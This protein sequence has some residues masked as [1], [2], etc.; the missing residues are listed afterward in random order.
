MSD[1]Q[2]MRPVYSDLPRWIEQDYREFLA[3]RIFGDYLKSSSG[4]PFYSLLQNY[5]AATDGGNFPD[6]LDFLKSS[7]GE[8]AL[9]EHNNTR[10]L[11]SQSPVTLDIP[12]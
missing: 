2:T 4:K 9:R 8:D 1:A 5:G 12:A 10:R 7:K 11:L 6:F 3:R